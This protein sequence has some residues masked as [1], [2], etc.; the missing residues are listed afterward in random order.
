MFR[1]HLLLNIKK[2]QSDIGMKN[3]RY[4]KGV[5][6]IILDAIDMDNAVKR[7]FDCHH[8]EEIKQRLVF[9]REQIEDYRDAVSRIITIRAD[10]KRMEVEEDNALKIG[11]GLI[12]EVN[13]MI[14]ATTIGLGQ[15]T[16]LVL[17]SL[18]KTNTVLFL[19]IAIGPILTTA[20]AF[21]II[22]EYS[23]PIAVLLDATRKLK[24]GNLDY[25]IE[26]LK[27]EFG[28]LADSFNEM[29]LSLKE[30]WSKLEESERKYRLLFENA[31][32]GISMLDAETDY[33]KII[34][35][36]PALAEMH[37][38]TRHE[39]L[40]LN[41][42]DLLVP[43]H[44]KK[45]DER[46]KKAIQDKR[47]VAESLHIRKDG[48]VFPVEVSASL[49]DI[50]GYKYCLTFDRNITER[51]QAE[52]KLV[53]TEQMKFCGEMAASLAH[54]IKNPLAGIMASIEV[55]HDELNI[56]ED[57]RMVM[58][59]IIEEIRRIESL[60]NELLS[61]ARPVRSQMIPVNVNNIIESVLT[62]Q[63]SAKNMEIKI[64]KS[65]DA[66]LPDIFVD[67]MQVK[68]AILNL[69]A[70]AV[71]AMPNGGV[72]SIKTSA[73]EHKGMVL[74][75]IADTGTGI[76]EDVKEKIFQP[77]FSTK[78]KGTGLGLA[79]TKQIIE[80]HG[81]TIHAYNNKDGGAVFTILLPFANEQEEMHA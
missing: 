27:D 75:E 72:V 7:C 11:E 6:A 64:V 81:G 16:Q 40:N 56:T 29:S 68:Q 26:G 34:D 44:A 3:T 47:F 37:G 42:R 38:Y 18:N 13:N 51:K 46:F 35:A 52:E 48:V 12:A 66:P 78:S 53:R 23:R 73:N 45:F 62:M 32:D 21:V 76:T 36:N 67:P 30:Y 1:E 19:L 20:L 49:V 10:V 22:K 2:V 33:G 17:N 80:Q 60:L 15:K 31:K 69:Y 25:R 57:D 71:E 5:D 50:D 55:L 63:T 61:F 41:R 77:F 59:T 79:I 24:E 4:A 58:K 74:I 28:E 54:E 70:N 65:L 9:L 39:L 8:R 43:E 14:V